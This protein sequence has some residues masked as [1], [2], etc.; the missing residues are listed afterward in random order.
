METV[1]RLNKQ[2]HTIVH[3]I[4]LRKDL[5]DD[6]HIY[7]AKALKESESEWST[8]KKLINTTNKGLQVCL[9]RN[10]AFAYFNVEF[11]WKPSDGGFL[12]IIENENK[13]EQEFGL[14]TICGM[15]G[16]AA[17]LVL[18][19]KR[20]DEEIESKRVEEFKCLWEIFD[21]TKELNNAQ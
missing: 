21:W 8:N 6:A 2:R 17:K 9:P 19:G 16:E 13:F 3:C 14:S 20:L 7:F 5:H 18:R 12:H 10:S 15:L 4:P 11:G 1:H